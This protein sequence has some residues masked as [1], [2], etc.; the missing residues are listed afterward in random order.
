MEE[1]KATKAPRLKQ[2]H[3]DFILLLACV[4]PHLS[5]E[6]MQALFLSKFGH[7]ITYKQLKALLKKLRPQIE[8]TNASEELTFDLAKRTGLITL[9][10]KVNRIMMLEDIARKALN[11]DPHEVQTARGTIVV[12]NKKDF[13]TSITAIKAIKEEAASDV[14][15][16]ST[17]IVQIQDA[18]PPTHEDYQ[19][20]ETDED[21]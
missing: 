10:E 6:Q 11:G 9:T 13:N 12:V 21:L 3:K 14:A 15:N 1:I 16:Q 18:T 19:S 5:Y 7:E 4:S 2:P 20:L 8:A 17:Y